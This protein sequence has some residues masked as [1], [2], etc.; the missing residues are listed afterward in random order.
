MQNP[1]NSVAMLAQRSTSFQRLAAI[2]AAIFLIVTV[3]SSNSA[4]AAPNLATTSAGLNAQTSKLTT[5]GD[6]ESVS[7]A[8]LFTQ[9]CAGCHARGGNVVRRSKTLKQKALKRYGYDSIERI[10]QIITN[11][12]GVMSGYG[13]R[14]SSAEIG[15]IAQYVKNQAESGWN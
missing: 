8:S 5:S 6:R 13:D 7:I 12:K 3:N 2:L 9:N 15:A 1:S 10:E 14:L 11:G 4:L